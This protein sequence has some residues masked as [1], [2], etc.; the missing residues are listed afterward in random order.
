MDSKVAQKYK[1]ENHYSNKLRI[2][3]VQKNYDVNHRSMN[4]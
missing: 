1:I 4:M 2:Y 3:T